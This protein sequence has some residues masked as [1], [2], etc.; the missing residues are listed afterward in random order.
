MSTTA[1]L[2]STLKTSVSCPYLGILSKTY[3]TTKPI[4]GNLRTLQ[5]PLSFNCIIVG[6]T[7]W[8]DICFTRYKEYF[9]PQEPYDFNR[10]YFFVLAVRLAFVIIF[11]YFV[12][13]IVSLL[14]WLIPDIPR[15]LEV[16]IM[17]ESY[18]AKQCLTRSEAE[19]S[20]DLDARV[21]H[22]E[23]STDSL[24]M[25]CENVNRSRKSS[26]IVNGSRL[27]INRVWW[28]R[29]SL[30]DGMIKILSGL[31]SLNLDF[32]LVEH[33]SKLIFCVTYFVYFI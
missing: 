13:F 22:T 4:A 23:G 8:A 19:A 17:R 11:Q 28:Q 3:L 25:S 27:G 7:Y 32:N 33:E 5:I 18:V 6:Q 24:Y 30:E 29:T 2:T 21:S 1:C 31:F 16:K 15:K 10:Q 14:D 9:D 12:F 26:S 20:R